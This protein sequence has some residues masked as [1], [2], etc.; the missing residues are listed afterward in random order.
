MKEKS[1][2]HTLTHS[3]LYDWGLILSFYFCCWIFI[4]MF[5]SI[6]IEFISS[7]AQAQHVHSHTHWSDIINLKRKCWRKGMVIFVF[8]FFF[9]SFFLIICCFHI[10]L[11]FC[12]WSFLCCYFA[13]LFEW[14][15]STSFPNFFFQSLFICLKTKLKTKKNG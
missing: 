1:N 4:S 11:L 14:W 15:N 6:S 13:V 5:C 12:W 10:F 3:S 9:F 2:T 8:N 7:R